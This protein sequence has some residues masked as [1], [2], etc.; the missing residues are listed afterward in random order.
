MNVA[1]DCVM[2]ILRDTAALAERGYW[3]CAECGD[4]RPMTVSRCRLRRCPGF[5]ATW[6]RD[7]LRKIREN[8]RCHG[9]QAAMLTLTAPGVDAGLIWD[10]SQCSHASGE[11]CGGPRSCRVVGPVAALWND[12]P[13]GIPNSTR[14]RENV[15]EPR[16]QGDGPNWSSLK[17]SGTLEGTFCDSSAAR[18]SPQPIRSANSTMIPS[19][20]RT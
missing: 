9:G 19:G 7:I 13:Q 10:R 16:G 17:P 4:L 6:A 18:R 11:K 14:S 3:R 2:P 1:A 20:P 8:L 15:W 5:S 12:R